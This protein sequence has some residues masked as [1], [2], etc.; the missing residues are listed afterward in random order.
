[1]K[2]TLLS[3]ALFTIIV[4]LT[5]CGGSGP[6]SSSEPKGVNPG[7]PSIVQLL[8][9]QAV[10]QTNSYLYFKAKV[11]DGNGNPVKNEPVTFTNLS[12]LGTLQPLGVTANGVGISAGGPV[13]V[14]TDSLGFATITLSSMT[15]GF[16]TVQAEVNTGAGMVRD[17]KTV[18][19][20]AGSLNL[21]PFMTLDVDGDVINGIFNEPGDF[22]FF[23][24]TT[25]DM[26]LFRS[27]QQFITRLAC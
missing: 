19:F 13:V 5:S 7:I 20:T 12:L 27:G 8:P 15:S 21:L 17:K 16:A 11:L 18:Y 3:I 4:S 26:I 22:I 2:K 23:E 10:A 24:T 14:N 9:V 25:D 1:M 6:G